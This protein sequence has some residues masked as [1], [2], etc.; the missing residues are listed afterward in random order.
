MIQ[1]ISIKGVATFDQIGIELK[2][3]KMIN[4]IYGSNGT[5]KSTISKILANVEEHPQCE[6]KW[7]D[8]A[9]ID[10]LSYNKDF[11]EKNYSEQIPGVF[12]LGETT[13]DALKKIAERKARLDEI[14]SLELGFNKDI[15]K[16]Q[17]TK[18]SEISSFR[19]SAW[20]D[21]LKH[22]EAH[23][24]KSS[25]GAGT[26]DTFITKLIAAYDNKYEPVVSIEKLKKKAEILFGAQPLQQDLIELIDFAEI[27]EVEADQIWQK[28]IVGKQDID[29]AGLIMRLGSSDW[30]NQGLHYMEEG[31]DICPFCQQN[32]ITPDFKEKINS[33]F[34]ES[35]KTDVG[36]IEQL[37]ER[38]KILSSE[39]I[40][41]I[42]E[43]LSLQKINEKSLL[44]ISALE[45]V[46]STLKATISGNIELLSSK[47]KEPGRKI[48]MTA[49]PDIFDEINNIIS[50]ANVAISENNRLA[51]NFVNERSQLIMDIWNFFADSYSSVID[52]HKKKLKGVEKAV[53][54]LNDKVEEARKQYSTVRS[55]LTTLENSV[56]SVTPTVNEINRLLRGYG[57]SNFHIQEI[58]DN[59]NH[60]QIVRENGEP[61]N[62]TLSE[63]E[64]TFITFLYYMQLVKGGYTPEGISNNRVLVIDDPVSS[65]DSN[66]LFVVSTLLRELFTDVHNGSSNVKQIIVLTHNVYFHK[67]IAFSN[68][69]D[70][71]WRDCIAHWI[72]RKRDNVSS[73]QPYG[74]ESPIKSSYELMWA[75]LKS[76]K[77][78]SCIVVQNIMRRIIENYFQIFGGI[79]PNVILE[80]FTVPEEQTICRSLL[81][82]VNDG[83]HSLPED[84]FVEFSDEQLD[85][86]KKVF[87]DIFDK[88]GQNAHYDMMMQQI[89]KE[90]ES[91]LLA[92]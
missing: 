87:H 2:D 8:D 19:E 17:D 4:V 1:K 85:K 36:K 33:F 77:Q 29:I 91:K 13:N 75:E 43:I 83:S 50:K 35:Y 71:K 21:L 25:I 48:S 37:K 5:G 15:Q 68:S 79:S 16:Q 42:E 52:S 56:T 81:S 72:L 9:S 47:V 78:N 28:V 60:Y 89:D 24:S 14:K 34:D 20:N 66:V 23:F 7:K 74:K 45:P 58:A 59:K 30:V 53:K 62:A 67:E 64:R 61:A 57:F 39:T 92:E 49:T 46:L 32:T 65:L 51:L 55:E 41:Q 86:Y 69:R 12:T 40:K 54:S 11:R 27:Q 82:W 90:D 18:E 80:K 3:L 73:I 63:G 38:Y 70:C 76:E 10:V 84:L 6:I 26:K 22:Y 31:S 88:M 44:D